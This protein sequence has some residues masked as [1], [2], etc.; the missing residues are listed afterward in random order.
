MRKERNLEENSIQYYIPTLQ[1]IIHFIVYSS[2]LM[3]NY[4]KWIPSIGDW[5]MNPF[6]YKVYPCQRIDVKSDPDEH[7]NFFLFKRIVL[8]IK[9]PM[10][11][12]VFPHSNS[13]QSPLIESGVVLAK[14]IEYDISRRIREVDRRRSPHILN[15]TP[16]LLY[17][18]SAHLR[19]AIFPSLNTLHENRLKKMMN[20]QLIDIIYFGLK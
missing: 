18:T 4:F 19:K 10:D 7:G 5:K 1:I 11:V 13:N 3:V 9:A 6:S 20:Q 16:L 14:A 2:T 12:Q 15:E 17:N 8:M